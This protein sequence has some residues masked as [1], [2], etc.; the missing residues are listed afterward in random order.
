MDIRDNQDNQYN[1]EQNPSV[2]WKPVG[3]KLSQK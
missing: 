2:P 1:Q 3:K